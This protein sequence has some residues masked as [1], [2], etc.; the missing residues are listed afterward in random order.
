MFVFVDILIGR[1]K[2]SGF[3]N[4]EKAKAK[5]KNDSCDDSS[6]SNSNSNSNKRKTRNTGKFKPENIYF[7]FFFMV[8]GLLFNGI[9]V[10]LFVCLL[11]YGVLDIGNNGLSRNDSSDGSNSNSNSNSNKRNTRNAGTFK[12]EKICLVFF[13]V[14]YT[15]FMVYCGYGVVLF[16]LINNN[17]N[18]N[19]S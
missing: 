4:K 14:V 19:R 2:K 13:V 18:N 17:N 1:T 10:C 8:N 15:H 12:P 11:W 5:R 16:C 7:V 9:V 6:N 3:R